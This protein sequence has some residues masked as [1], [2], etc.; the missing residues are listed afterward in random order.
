M[1]VS[2]RL[3]RTLHQA[4]GDEGA[5]DMVNW[6]QQVDENRKV[7]RELN[8][9]NYERFENRLDARFAAIESKFDAKFTAFEA[10]LTQL[11]DAR[12]AQVDARFAQ[13]D[14]RFGRMDVRFAEQ[15]AKFERRHAE[16]LKWSLAFWVSAVG[17]IA[18]LAGVL[19]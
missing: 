7:L 15:D 10:R 2:A 13:V 5:E 1:A 12:F 6:M 11:L 4:L 9:L 16:L 19:R 3:S 17:S 8:D 14:A 18:V